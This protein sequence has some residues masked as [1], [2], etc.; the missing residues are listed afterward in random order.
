M[1]CPFENTSRACLGT[2]KIF[3][4]SFKSKATKRLSFLSAKKRT[5][6]MPLASRAA[7]WS[8]SY[9]SC[10]LIPGHRRRI[11]KFKPA[12]TQSMISHRKQARS[13]IRYVSWQNQAHPLPPMSI[14]TMRL[15]SIGKNRPILQ[16]IL[17]PFWIFFYRL[18]I[19]A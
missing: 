6:M 18:T 13:Y 9:C 8:F 15:S 2:N 19:D 16:G 1:P 14:H 12:K 11:F 17:G 10:D 5:V 7:S 4:Q 3:L